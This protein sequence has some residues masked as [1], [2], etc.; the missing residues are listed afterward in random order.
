M[1]GEPRRETELMAMSRFHRARVVASES[2]ARRLKKKP[3]QGRAGRGKRLLE[4]EVLG[5]NTIA[6]QP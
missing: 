1:T 4:A 6:G 2:H 5:C 3:R